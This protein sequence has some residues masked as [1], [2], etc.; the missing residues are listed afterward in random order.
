MRVAP[1]LLFVLLSVPTLALS[2]GCSQLNLKK[3]ECWPFAKEEKPGIPQR[4]VPIWTD[5]VRY[6]QGKVPE[7]GFGGRLMFY[8]EPGGSPIKVEGELVV[9]AFD[10]TDRDPTNARPDRKFVFTA[11]SFDLHYSKSKLG[12][13]YSVWLPWD[14]IGGVR[15]E[16]SLI[17]R[18]QPTNGP[19]VV[20]EQTKQ[21]LPGTDPSAKPSTEV[22]AENPQNGNRLVS[23]EM[24]LQEMQPL[25]D[26]ST[27]MS[28]TTIDV[29]AGHGGPKPI[30]M[31][32][33]V[34]TG[35]LPQAATSQET[36]PSWATPAPPMSPALP[37]HSAPGQSRVPEALA[38]RLEIDHTGS[39]L[40]PA[41]SLSGPQPR[42][43]SAS[44]Y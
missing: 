11:R 15:K 23:Y 10:E 35:I 14:E 44:L 34:S 24:P 8:D 5:A 3:P 42:P 6:E 33:P 38:G 29:P 18:F 21:L 16:I 4:I 2:T 22:A 32:A 36:R 27:R 30:G 9:Y 31:A 25:P 40:H 43:R 12:H 7:R 19:L 13:S 28:C 20:S 17:V 1:R 41:R 26:P 39:Q 37:G